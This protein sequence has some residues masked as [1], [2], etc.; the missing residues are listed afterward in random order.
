VNSNFPP[1]IGAFKQLIIQSIR[2]ETDDFKTFFFHEEHRI[3]YE[4]GQFLTLIDH[5]GLQ[6]IR[7][8]YSI[9]SSP[10][11]NEPLAIGVKRM[12]NGFFSR[13]LFDLAKTGD[14]LL[15]TGVSGF[16]IL[17]ENIRS[18]KSIFFFAAGS[19]ITPILSLIKTTLIICPGIR[20]VLVYSNASIKRTAYYQDLKALE[21][22]F[23][24]RFNIF[25]LF[26][27]NADLRKARL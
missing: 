27:S 23:A 20:V 1:S 15:T 5:N 26:S 12:D 13:K 2:K 16:F 11:L 19:G 25:F 24:E 9:I 10:V 3:H 14:V 8:S 21:R 22:Q 6:E 17:P 4:S 18:C 7:R